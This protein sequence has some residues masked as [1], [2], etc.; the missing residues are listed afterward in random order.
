MRIAIITNSTSYEPRVFMTA[1]FFAE[2]GHEVILILSDFIHR[3]KIKRKKEKENIIYVETIPYNRNISLRRLY[4]HY[5]FSKKV[6]HVLEN[7]EL[8]LLYVLIPANSLLKFTSLYKRKTGTR[9]I[10]DILDL[11][12]ESLPIP[13]LKT[14]WPLSLWSDLRNRN[15]KNADLV[16]TECKLYQERL[17]S[18]LIGLKVMN[19]Y[20]PRQEEKKDAFHDERLEE[21]LQL[22][23]LG[24]INHIID[25]KFLIELL[26][27]LKKYRKVTL[28]VIGD[29]E[30]REEFLE[31]LVKANISFEYYGSVYDEI[32][33]IKILSMCHYGLNIMKS[34]VCV[35]VTMKSIDYLFAG[36][37][38][39]NNIKGDTWNLIEDYNIGF[40]CDYKSLY[41]VGKK[42]SKERIS[43]TD[44][45]RVRECYTKN[46]SKNAY[47]DSM[48][49]CMEAIYGLEEGKK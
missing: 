6:Y 23:Y 30:N 14:I 21:E 2:Q 10:V 24:S 17:S 8:D 40:N 5:N 32:E 13:F 19:I 35:G 12:P 39:I 22:C 44:R 20:W 37:S 33:K 15:L 38:L 47:R 16:I 34:S 48:K 29:G 9:L 41:E 46:F 28:H 4:S 36:L 49:R 45:Q 27:C 25:M 11:W 31:K 18:Y 43:V 3:E 26:V 1:E 7:M 42:V